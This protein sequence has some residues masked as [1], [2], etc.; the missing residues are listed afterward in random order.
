MKELRME[1]ELLKNRELV[2]MKDMIEL[3]LK[4]REEERI[5]LEKEEQERNIVV[6]TV[7][8]ETKKLKGSARLD[9][10]KYESE[11]FFGETSR[12][13]DTNLIVT[14]ATE[15]EAE[16]ILSA[17]ANELEIELCDCREIEKLSN[18]KVRVYDIF[19][20]EYDHGYMAKTK[21]DLMADFKAVKKDLGIR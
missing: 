10:A 9:F 1:L 13:V 5:A 11:D 3:I 18:G 14:A 8:V 20:V 16:E 19:M 6:E 17:I 2:E 4:E 7:E 12:A 15:E 21:K